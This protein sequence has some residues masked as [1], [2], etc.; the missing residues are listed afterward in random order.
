MVDQ[1]NVWFRLGYTLE[2]SRERVPRADRLR[3]LEERQTTRKVGANRTRRP[4][5]GAR[6][7]ASP[8]GEPWDALVAVGAT[9]LLGRVLEAMPRRRKPGLLRLLRAGAA[10]VGAALLSELLRSLRSGGLPFPIAQLVQNASLTGGARG[11]VYGALVEPRIPGPP[12]VRG[13]A[14]GSLEYLVSPWGGLTKLVGARAPHRRIPFL[15]DLLDDVGPNDDSLLDHVLFGIVLATLYG[16]GPATPY[17][18]A[19]GEA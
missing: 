9:A 1:D 16:A 14:Y 17:E 12:V 19:E 11:L 15:A 7:G 18:N 5:P 6:L 4:E 2:R 10:G 3:T 8:T 13:V